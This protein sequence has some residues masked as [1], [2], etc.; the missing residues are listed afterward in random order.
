MRAGPEAGVTA[1]SRGTSG[2]Q[3]E[4]GDKGQ[5]GT[6]NQPHDLVAMNLPSARVEWAVQ[7]NPDAHVFQV[8]GGRVEPIVADSKW[9]KVFGPAP[10]E[11]P[12]SGF[13]LTG[14]ANVF[15][16]TINYR[17]VLDSGAA[18]GTVPAEASDL[19][20]TLQVYWPSPMDGSECDLIEIPLR[21]GAAGA[22]SGGG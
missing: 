15:E 7:G 4:V 16:G 11:A 6:P 19:D 5:P 21:L 17:L 13:L 3:G 10:G 1:A 20:A 2:E 12:S 18:A 8:L 14:L 22:A 9:I